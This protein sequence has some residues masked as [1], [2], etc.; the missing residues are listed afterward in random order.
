MKGA[1]NET[2]TT[3]CVCVCVCVYIYIYNKDILDNILK[4]AWALLGTQLNVFKYCYITV[5]I[6]HQSFVCTHSLFYL[7]HRKDRIRWYHSGQSGTGGNGNKKVFEI[8]KAGTSPWDCFM[9]Y[10]GDLLGSRSY[11]SAAWLDEILQLSSIFVAL[12]KTW[13]C[14]L[15]LT[16]LYIN[17]DRE[18]GQLI[19]LTWVDE[20]LLPSYTSCFPDFRVLS[21]K[22][23]TVH[24]WS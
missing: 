24:S 21:L 3:M 1:P 10:P 22:V 17:K 7:T 20:I 11:L 16:E 18:E 6:Q 15:C 14:K 12:Y 8:S 2:R 19:L 23:E 4:R 9:S 5:T 13:L